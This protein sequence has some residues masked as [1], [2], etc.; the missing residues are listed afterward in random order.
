MSKKDFGGDASPVNSSAVL[1]RAR[2]WGWTDAPASVLDEAQVCLRWINMRVGEIMIESE[3]MTDHEVSELLRT[4]PE[5]V[6]TLD[7]FA[8]NTSGVKIR[9]LMDRV[10]SLK[11]GVAFY[12][13]LGLLTAHPAMR[14]SDV[15][16]RCGDLDAALM[17]IEM[18][19]PVLVFSHWDALFSFSVAGQ[20]ARMNDPIRKKL[21]GAELK[22]ACSRREEI[23]LVLGTVATGMT[24]DAA[25]ESDAIWQ[26]NTSE[27]PAQKE[28]ARLIEQGISLGATDISFKPFRNGSVQVLMRQY[29]DLISPLRDGK[30]RMLDGELATEMINFMSQKSG[31]NPKATRLMKPCDGQIT[32][33]SSSGDVFLRL[34]FIPLQHPGERRD[35][36]SVS[37]RLLPRAERSISV[38]ELKISPKVR[39]SIEMAMRL[40][41]GFVLV[42]GPTNSGKST[43]IGG[44]IGMH[45]DMYGDTRK[46][47]SAEE[48]IERFYFG[49][50]Q[51]NVRELGAKLET[52]AA[53][54]SFSPILRAMKRHDPDVIIVGE[55]R[56]Q[57]TGNMSVSSATSGHLVISTIHSN[58]SIMAIDVLARMVDP[59]MSF[60]LVESLSLILSQRL[61]K[62][63]CP[64][65]RTSG[66]TKDEHRKIWQHYREVIG[67]EEYDLPDTLYFANP[68]GCPHP[69][70]S[71]GYA[72]IAPVNEVL[73]F[74]RKAKNFASRLLHDPAARE[75]LAKMRTVK[76]IEEILAMLKDGRADL[77]SVLV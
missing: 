16:R 68:A 57:A 51:I 1:A 21:A 62:T 59:A 45:V 31:A 30:D 52:E 49:V 3:V 56:D 5:S 11:R 77:D 66:P 7:W 24:G 71:H 19:T 14:E 37:M 6:K 23:G 58:D 10:L 63:L 70:C 65:C 42:A 50:T 75:E 60:Q 67:D 74:T 12:E 41:R 46:R 28:L 40:G 34:S 32:Y 25:G 33:R 54:D 2:E 69:G 53:E 47:L 61:V 13:D 73:P 22:L 18:R 43:T 17:L 29:G 44:A 39:E 8:Q 27:L 36:T 38:D 48:P 76:M 4:K 20:E 55:I 26:G 64:D 35:L 15:A 9:S 72:G